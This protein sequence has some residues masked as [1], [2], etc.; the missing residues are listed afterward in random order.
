[1][2]LELLKGIHFQM[3]QPVDNSSERMSAHAIRFAPLEHL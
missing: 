2:N 3:L 1:M